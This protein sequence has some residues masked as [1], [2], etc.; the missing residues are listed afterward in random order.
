VS[1]DGDWKKA[2]IS[3]AD[4]NKAFA[5]ADDRYAKLLSMLLAQAKKSKAGS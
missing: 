2:K 1:F 5:D 4:Y 3:E